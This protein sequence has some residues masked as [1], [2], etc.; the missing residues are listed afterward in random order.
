[1]TCVVKP[2]KCANK[3]QDSE[4]GHG[5]RVFNT[6][7]KGFR[8]TICGKDAVQSVYTAPKSTESKK[9]KKAGGKKKKI[10]G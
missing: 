1:M 8:C 10:A 9:Q 3:F 6:T 4:Y 5:L 7:V 2:C